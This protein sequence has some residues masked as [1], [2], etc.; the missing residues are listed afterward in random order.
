L[1]GVVKLG[2]SALGPTG[3]LAARDASRGVTAEETSPAPPRQAVPGSGGFLPRQWSL[4]GTTQSARPR[5]L[6]AHLPRHRQTPDFL[7]RPHSFPLRRNSQRMH[8]PLMRQQRSAIL[9][10]WQPREPES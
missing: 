7:S 10:P 5:R 4:C 1:D 8:H 9:L 3:S 2:P 6:V